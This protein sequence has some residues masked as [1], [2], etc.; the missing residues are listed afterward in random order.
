LEGVL[1]Q[2]KGA[3]VREKKAAKELDE[4]RREKQL[5]E[6]FSS[7]IAS[8]PSLQST[9]RTLVATVFELMPLDSAAVFLGSPPEPFSYRS[10]E[11][12]TE[13]LQGAALTGLREP[14]VDRAWSEK[15]PALQKEKPISAERLLPDD[16]VAAAVPLA[17]LGVLYVAR[18]AM[19]PFAK[20]DLERLQWLAGKAQLALEAGYQANLDARQ[21]REQQQTVKELERKVAW[22]GSLMGGAEAFASTL[23]R[24]VL[25]DRFVAVLHQVVPHERG[26]V[27]AP[28]GREKSWGGEVHPDPE[29]ITAVR[30]A[31]RPFHLDDLAH[32]RFV[33]PGPGLASLVASPLLAHQQCLGVVVLASERAKAFTGEQ[34]DLLF[35]LSSQVAMALSNAAHFAEVVEARR[36]LEESQARLIQSSKMTALGQLAAGVAHELNSPIGA[37]ALC[38]DVA[39]AQ[40]R[41]K[42]DLA[43]RLLVKG[44]EALDRSKEII[45]RL[46]AYSRKP[47]H[48]TQKMSLRELA[49]DTLDFLSYQIKD[50]GME[51]EFECADEATLMGEP[52][53]LQQVLT[54][55][56]LNAA[57]AVEEVPLERRRLSLRVTS[58]AEQVRIEVADLGCGIAAQHLPRIFEPFY[59]TKP[60]G[61]GTGLGLWAS[62]QIVTEHGGDLS[63]SSTEGVGSTFTV[64][65]PRSGPP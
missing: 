21:R 42:P 38:L 3:Q 19:T 34:I 55:L 49:R 17:T 33:T 36:K 16:A 48:Q 58:D 54:N 9:A 37:I 39:S 30:K 15:K 11:A 59:T 25:L 29:L 63:V 10:S 57:Q 64:T 43:A 2:L 24:T 27:V 35:V 7:H 12:Q 28:A 1:K 60:I 41:E 32:S 5:L 56:I 13:R 8:N 50:K 6:G 14:L 20:K 52:Q 44:Q 65:L 47:S 4:T 62:H 45:S 26:A 23:D 31:G 22:L 18:A 40:L 61:K 46:L 51:V 53:P